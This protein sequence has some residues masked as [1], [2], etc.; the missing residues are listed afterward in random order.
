MGPKEKPMH[1]HF[2][3]RNISREGKVRRKQEAASGEVSGPCD[4]KQAVISYR[5]HCMGA[6]SGPPPDEPPYYGWILNIM[7]DRLVAEAIQVNIPDSWDDNTI[8]KQQNMSSMYGSLQENGNADMTGVPPTED[9]DEAQ[10]LSLTPSV[11]FGTA[12]DQQRWSQP[13]PKMFNNR[14][15]TAAKARFAFGNGNP[16]L[17][18]E[19]IKVQIEYYKVKTELVK[20]Q[21]LKLRNNPPVS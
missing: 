16:Q 8:I 15:R 2:L 14:K 13:Q 10:S 1:V 9:S 12:A 19:L 17:C 5:I 7:G 6:G 20:E 4:L 11:S 3:K 18:D 21:L